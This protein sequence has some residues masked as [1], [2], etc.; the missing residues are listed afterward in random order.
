MLS[1]MEATKERKD[2]LK[3]LMTTT[4]LF[5]P[6]NYVIRTTQQNTKIPLKYKLLLTKIIFF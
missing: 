1:E 6:I 3:N 2:N 4:V 5:I